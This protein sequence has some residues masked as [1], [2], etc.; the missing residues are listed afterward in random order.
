V[1]VKLDSPKGAYYGGATAAPVS[2]AMM[3]AALAR[4]RTPLDRGALLE[5]TRRARM[6]AAPEPRAPGFASAPAVRFASA[7]LSPS[8]LPAVPK[9]APEGAERRTRDEEPVRRW[10]DG[11]LPVPDVGG[12]APREAVRRLHSAGLRVVWDGGSQVTGSSPR[13][14]SRAQPG[15]TIRLQTRGVPRP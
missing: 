8:A 4:S 13:A 6:S 1:F 10:A 14:G 3:E 11:S 7:E 9:T 15:D 12:L 2:R 5:S